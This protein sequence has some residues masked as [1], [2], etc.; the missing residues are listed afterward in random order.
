MGSNLTLTECPRDSWQGL[1]QVILTEHKIA[2]LTRLIEAGFQSL[3]CASFVS[4]KAVPQM[5]DSG[6]VLDALPPAPGV[7]IIAIV[8]NGRGLSEALAHPRVTT[9]GYPLSVNETFQ[10]LNT[11]RSL[12]TS[13]QFAGDLAR[14]CRSA[15]RQVVLYLSMAFGNPYREPWSLEETVR[16]AGRGVE[17]GADR[18]MLADTVGRASP[19]LVA[20]LIAR[21]TRAVPGGRFGV[22]LH[23]RPD[24]SAALAL[25]ALAAGD[26]GAI[27][28]ALGGIGGCPFAQEDL[29]GNL[30]TEVVWPALGERGVKLPI[31]PNA[32][33]GLAAAARDLA[34][35]HS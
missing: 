11:K 33:D 14:E 16:A 35:G 1:H 31:D 27:D 10:Q 15:G 12:A 25:A 20:A 17:L 6:A 3:D 8:A 30:A 5:A 2:H 28:T 32:L 22:H 9:L 13:W 4:P 29:V 26:I 19:A 34:A 24:H 21:T 23:G 7:E 18:V